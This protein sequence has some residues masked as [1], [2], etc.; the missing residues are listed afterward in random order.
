MSRGVVTD[1]TAI[2]QKMS[3][4]IKTVTTMGERITETETRVSRLE[5][6]IE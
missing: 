1:L 5:D 6:L 2:E 3:E 4:F